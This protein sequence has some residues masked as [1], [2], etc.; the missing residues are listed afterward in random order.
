MNNEQKNLSL[1]AHA[2]TTNA[3]KNKTKLSFHGTLATVSTQYGAYRCDYTATR[4]PDESFY[5]M[6]ET[7]IFCSND[8][9]V[10]KR[11]HETKSV[12][13]SDD[14]ILAGLKDMIGIFHD[15]IQSDWLKTGSKI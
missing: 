9:H 15:D 12:E 13:I 1:C 3:A 5:Q 6:Y 7:S 8:G 2:L 11:V 14:A 4:N 10:L